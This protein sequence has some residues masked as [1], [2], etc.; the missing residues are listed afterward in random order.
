MHGAVRPAA[1][2][3]SLG[4]R[5][6]SIL[7]SMSWPCRVAMLRAA[8]GLHATAPQPSGRGRAGLRKS[9][10]PDVALLWTAML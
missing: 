6:V 2:L 5:K 7:V 4:L 8:K 9:L 1:V 3:W 10:H